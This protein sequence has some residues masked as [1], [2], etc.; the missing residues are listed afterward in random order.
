MIDS[1]K[2]SQFAEELSNMPCPFCGKCHKVVLNN[3]GGDAYNDEIGF[4]LSEGSCEGFKEHLIN[5]LS[6]SR[7]R[8]VKPLW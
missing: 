3:R 8:F 1:V 7:H 2:L 5:L 6:N 4:R